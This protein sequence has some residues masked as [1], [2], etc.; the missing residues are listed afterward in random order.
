MRLIQWANDH[1]KADLPQTFAEALNARRQ[2]R[3]EHQPE[4]AEPLGAEP[5]RQRHRRAFGS[6]SQLLGRGRDRSSG[7]IRPRQEH[8]NRPRQRAWDGLGRHQRQVPVRRLSEKR[9][10]Q[11]RLPH[12]RRQKAYGQKGDW[13]AVS[14]LN[15][16]Q[17]LRLYAQRQRSR[18]G[19][20]DGRRRNQ[21]GCRE[22]RPLG[23]ENVRA[24]AR[25]F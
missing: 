17:N 3:N 4:C 2:I 23:A 5:A 20:Y 24:R 7:R 22:R 10:G 14:V 21:K 16:Q 12:A 19:V 25:A 11:P 13:E 6:D 8:R 15:R 1:L 18:R 9:R